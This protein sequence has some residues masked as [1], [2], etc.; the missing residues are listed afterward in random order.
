MG[1]L[2]D[3]KE[4]ADEILNHPEVTIISHIDADG[5]ASETILSRALERKGITI[6]SVFVRQLEPLT[7]HQVPDDASFKVFSD[8]GAGQQN[9]FMDRGFRDNDLLII[10][11]HVSQPCDIPYR[12]LNCLT[13]GITKMSTAGLAYFLAREMDPVNKDLAHLGV[14]G[15]VGDMMARE[16]CGLTGPAKEI[17][18][19]GI[20]HGS[21]SLR[22]KDLNCYGTSTRPLHICLAYN[23]DPYIPGISNDANGALRFLKR[24]N[25]QKGPNGWEQMIWEEMSHED[26]KKIMS[27]L[28]E[29]AIVNGESP[30][31]LFCETYLFPL[32]PEK[33]PLRNAQEFA[34]LL[35]ACGR[36]AKPHTGGRIC[37]GD[38][39][40]A[41]RDAE[42]MLMNHR[43]VIRELLQYIL[44]TGVSEQPYLQHIHV[45]NRYP[46]TIIGIGAG[47]ALSKLNRQ[48]PILIMCEL[49]ED[50]T[51][52]KASM[53]TTE[54]VVSRG[55]D[56]QH[57]IA[58][59]AEETG[60]A[61]GGHKIAAG[62]YIP[63]ASEERFIIRVNELLGEQYA[64]EN[65]G[66]R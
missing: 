63:R 62:A 1:L 15:N 64:P 3:V 45:G 26:R 32:E 65:S 11:H 58:L 66:H 41:Y 17:V 36:W 19:D 10:D 44:D 61:G 52:T 14:V 33:T 2:G 46:D 20:D 60:G 35:N 59:A 24:I 28:V 47:M 57:I 25:I 31:R 48:K 6:N 8:L 34:T 21:I 40:A 50:P 53:R 4:A 30:E 29:Q 37:R 49:P 27:A 23:D 43:S 38:R 12:Q 39:G 16:T 56:L 42:K 9:L 18:R 51:L 13:C 54:R 5:I 55:I 22:E 7:M